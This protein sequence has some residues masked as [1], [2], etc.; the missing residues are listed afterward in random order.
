[1]NDPRVYA[2][3]NEVFKKHM[4][5]P[6]AGISLAD[7]TELVD[8]Y[9][10]GW[11]VRRTRTSFSGGSWCYQEKRLISLA[12]DAGLPLVLHELAHALTPKDRGHGLAFQRAYLDLIAKEMSP[13]WARRLRA[14]F[15]RHGCKGFKTLRAE[16]ATR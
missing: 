1:M 14:A 2:A 13:Y 10:M 12:R 16:N 7:A 6:T 9:A 11:T 5:G 3:E 15:I 8:R 4:R